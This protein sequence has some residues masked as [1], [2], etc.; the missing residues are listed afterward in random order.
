MPI[1]IILPRRLTAENL[2][3]LIHKN[4]NTSTTIPSEVEFD[5]SVVDFALPSGIVFL[6][7]LSR[8]L[9][10]QNCTVVYSEMN[11]ENRCIRFLDDSLF[12]EQHMGKKLC[13]TCHPRNTTR[14]LMEIR[15]TDSHNWIRAD[16]IP[17]LSESADV[18]QDN[19]SELATCIGELFNNINDHTEFDVGSI[20]A[21]WFPKKKK[22]VISIADFGNGIPSTVARKVQSLSDS[23][24]I[25]KAFEDGFTTQSTP[26]NRGAGL[27]ILVQNVVGI[28]NG[29]LTVHSGNGSVIF[30][31]GSNSLMSV[32]YTRDGFCPGTLINLEFSTNQIEVIEKE[33]GGFEW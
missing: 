18:P 2:F 10:R 11:N 1:S 27:F 15:H 31:K 33:T 8:Y 13:Q 29:E 23:E 26:R 22:V 9:L 32:P 5:F 20:F 6:S 21:Q 30:R 3:L 17:W 14:P 16:L 25:E 12:F 19:L 24:A 7:N 28:L 4:F